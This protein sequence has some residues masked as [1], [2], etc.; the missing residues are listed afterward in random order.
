MRAEW[1]VTRVM[2]RRAAVLMIMYYD[3]TQYRD[4]VD[5]AL[6]LCDDG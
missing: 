3:I 6:D 5:W 1:A 4:A 2:V